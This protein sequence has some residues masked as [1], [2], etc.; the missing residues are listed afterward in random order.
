MRCSAYTDLHGGFYSP[1]HPV[2]KHPQPMFLPQCQR[3][4]FLV[5]RHL[6]FFVQ[7]FLTSIWLY[8]DMN[9]THFLWLNFLNFTSCISRF[10]LINNTIKLCFHVVNVLWVHLMKLRGIQA[11]YKNVCYI[12]ELV[13]T[14]IDVT[15]EKICNHSYTSQYLHLAI[16][17]T[18]NH[19]LK[20]KR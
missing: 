7:Q 14:W 10:K 17:A 11:T 20:N 18:K 2:L 4:S 13:N 5:L 1:Q 19:N 9:G 8:S 16:P 12:K 3:P 6:S 15:T